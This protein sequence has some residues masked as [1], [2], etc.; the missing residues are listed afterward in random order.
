MN[1]LV[2]Y[3]NGHNF[4]LKEALGDC[5]EGFVIGANAIGVGLFTSDIEVFSGFFCAKSHG[6]PIVGVLKTINHKGVEDLIV[7]KLVSLSELEKCEGRD[8]LFSRDEGYWT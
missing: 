2:L 6:V 7:S 8:L 4:L 1:Y 5:G 3:L